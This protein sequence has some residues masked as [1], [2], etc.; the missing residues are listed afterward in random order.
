M[1]PFMYG[2]IA[3]KENFFYSRRAAECSEQDAEWC[4]GCAMK[5][6]S[7]TRWECGE[8]YPKT[9]RFRPKIAG[10]GRNLPKTT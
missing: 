3:E 8:I 1:V 2:L 6:G 9:H 7:P 10:C 5:V 4:M